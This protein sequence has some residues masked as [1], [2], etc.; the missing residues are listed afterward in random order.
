[1]VYIATIKE[2]MN[3][4]IISQY[5]PF[6]FWGLLVALIHYDINLQ[7]GDDVYFSD[8]LGDNGT[9]EVWRQYLGQRYHNWTSRL[10]IEGVLV[11]VV[12][13]PLLWKIIDTVLMIWIA[14][15]ISIFFNDT[16]NVKMNWWIILI[17][18]AF[19]FEIM[20]SAGWI[21]TTLN[22]LWPL[23][24]GFIG[25]IPVN[26]LIKKKKNSMLTIFFSVIALC[27][28]INQEQMC[29]LFV[30]FYAL[31]MIYSLVKHKKVPILA[32]IILVLSFIMLGYHALCP[33]NELRKVAEM[34]AYYPAFYGFKLM[35][36]LLL[37]V[38]ST[39]AIGSLQPAYIIFVWNI[40]LIYII[41]KNTKNKGQYILIGL[42]TF[43]TFVVSVSDRYCNHRG[44]YQIFNVFNDYTKVIEHISLNMN[45]CLIILYF[46]CILLISFYVIK[47]NLGNKT[48]FLSFIIICAAFCSRVVLGFSPSIFVSG[49][50]TF[51]NSYFLIVIATF[52]CV[53]SRKLESM[54]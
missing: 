9:F 21:A 45:V 51:V 12:H 36:K 24:F 46:I 31:F 17:M 7:W 20:N 54:L 4:I 10:I 14:K 15:A 29:A 47:I 49:T 5:F 50:R 38:L 42:M 41:Y 48:M 44:F 26:N 6:V 27:Y 25:M 28:A 52:L 11:I 30:G 18:L 13:Y 19:P 32:Y 23:A 40:M 53:N 3:K 37:G 43:V 35:D 8:V 1:M 22:Y 16:K 39:I 2:K 34:N 33:G